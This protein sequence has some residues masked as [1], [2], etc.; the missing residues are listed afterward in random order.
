[1]N[2]RN[3]LKT[4]QDN[5]GIFTEEN[6]RERLKGNSFVDSLAAA[7]KGPD[8]KQLADDIEFAGE[9]NPSVKSLIVLRNNYFAHRSARDAI[10]PQ[11]LN[12][13]YPLTK[14]DVQK[15]LTGGLEILNRY[16]AL[17]DA[18]LYANTIVGRDDYETVL[19][20]VRDKLTHS[21]ERRQKDEQRA[22]EK[23]RPA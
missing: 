21:D 2:L 8:P 20:A 12:L 4:I 15:L 14:E 16:S 19:R 18:Q 5:L 13:R 10:E 9:G 23:G 11:D 7:A 22:G 17:F 3:F 1:M 6:F